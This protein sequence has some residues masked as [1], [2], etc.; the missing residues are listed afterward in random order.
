MEWL[1][2]KAW[3]F[4]RIWVSKLDISHDNNKFQNY[5]FKQDFRFFLSV[6]HIIANTF[7]VREPLTAVFINERIID[8]L[9]WIIALPNTFQMLRIIETKKNKFVIFN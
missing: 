1:K 3:S 4:L 2:L 8:E 5:R 6:S 7:I 9:K